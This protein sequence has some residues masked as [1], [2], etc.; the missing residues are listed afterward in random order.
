MVLP[1]CPNTGPRKSIVTYAD[2]GMSHSAGVQISAIVPEP[3]F[4]D[5]SP[6]IPIKLSNIPMLSRGEPK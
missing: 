3:E 1:S 5:I 6:R 2:I 4:L